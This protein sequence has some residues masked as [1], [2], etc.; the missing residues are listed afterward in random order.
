MEQ[1]DIKGILEKIRSGIYTPEDEAI[2]KYWLN[3][4]QQHENSELS[5]SELDAISDEMW[6]E[7]TDRMQTKHAKIIRLWPRIAAAASIIIAISVCGYFLFHK[8]HKQDIAQNQIQDITPGHSQA[9]LILANG[10]K[11]FLTKNL[12]GNLAQQGN[13]LVQVNGNNAIAYS[14]NGEATAETITYN[15]MLTGVGEQS[16][17]PLLLAD[18]TQILLDAKS[19]VTFPIAFNGIDRRV[20]VRGKAWFKVKP[21]ANRPFYVDAGGQVTKEIGTE[22]IV[23]AYSDDPYVTTTLI[24]GSIEVIKGEQRKLVKPGQQALT[25]PGNSI[26]NLKDADIEETTAWIHGYFLFKDEKINEVMKQLSRWYKIDVHYQGKISTEGFN[27]KVSRN[28]NI[29]VILRVLQETNGVHF[30]IQGK[31]VTVIQ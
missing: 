11:I 25:S 9:T 17:Y 6:L 21:I 3:Q 2:A 30:K 7:V 20:K 28:K 4:L 15:T 31:E 5:K 24:E 14:T 13:M 18:G 27:G 19:S 26:I 16:P 22:F 23:N 8:T 10:K 12:K 1:K 29:S